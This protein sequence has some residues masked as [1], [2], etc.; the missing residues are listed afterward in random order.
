M[1]ISH[2]CFNS[3]IIMSRFELLSPERIAS[4]PSSRDGISEKDENEMRREGCSFLRSLCKKLDL[5]PFD[6][7]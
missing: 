4:S 6:S 2:N 3:K 1:Y 5:Y 7:I